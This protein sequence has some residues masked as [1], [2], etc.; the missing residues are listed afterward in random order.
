MSQEH[1]NAEPPMKLTE[2]N[3]D[4]VVSG[5][6]PVFVDYWAVWC[7]PCRIMDPVVDRLAAKYSGRVVFGKVNVD[8][9]MNISSRYQVFSIPTF[10]IFR[11]GQPMDA[12]IGAVGEAS[13]EKLI[14]GA[15]G[16]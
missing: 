10:M 5:P 4:R 14:V 1:K 15:I 2:E 12:V 3:F 6:K 16:G 8:E 11:N 13:L 9:E 7:G